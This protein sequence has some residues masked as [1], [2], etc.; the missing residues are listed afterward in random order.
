MINVKK[1]GFRHVGQIG[2]FVHC[3]QDPDDDT[4]DHQIGIV[5][6]MTMII[7][8]TMTMMTMGVKLRK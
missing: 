4:E 8:I 6:M 7:T 3:Y 1:D 5:I 2:W